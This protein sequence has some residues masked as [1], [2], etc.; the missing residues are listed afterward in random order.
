M[1]N[2]HV[3]IQVAA[4]REEVF[5]KLA[6]MRNELEW[7]EAVTE[8]RKATEGDIGPGTRFE[9]K[10]KRGVGPMQMEIVD[11]ER[12]NRIRFRGGGRPADVEFTATFASQGEGTGV[13][14][15]LTLEP[16][17]MAKIFAPMM[18]RRVA[19]DEAKTMD[20]FRRWVER[21]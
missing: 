15:T 1:I 20:S 21:G 4:P 7:N 14:A 2:A 3:D 19:R 13:G 17:G 8:M 9:G 12:P 11:Y 6:D 10:M 18:R 16:K 5:D